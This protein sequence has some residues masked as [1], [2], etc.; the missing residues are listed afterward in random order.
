MRTTDHHEAL[1]RRGKTLHFARV[2]TKAP[3]TGEVEV[4]LSCVGVCGT[5]LQIL[6]GSRPDTA[7]ILGHEG[8]GIVVRAP[9]VDGVT[10]GDQVVF[11]PAAQLS[12]GRILGHNTSGLFQQYITLEPEAVRD[13]LIMS[14]SD[15]SATLCGILVEPLACVIYGYELLTRRVGCIRTA[16]V[17]GAGPVG[18]LAAIYL[19]DF[20]IKTFL[21]HT[22]PVRLQT[23]KR[24]EIASA[25]I[26][27][28]ATDDAVEQ[29][30]ARNGDYP[31][32]IAFICTTRIG[33]PVALWQAIRIVRHGGCVDLV[34]NYPEIGVGTLP[35]SASALRLV[36]SENVCGLPSEGKYLDTVMG[37]RRIAFTGHRG[38]SYAHLR[39]AINVLCRNVPAYS[40]MITHVLPLRESASAIQS[41]SE[42]RSH[43]VLGRD[44][45]KLAIDMSGSLSKDSSNIE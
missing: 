27:L 25:V 34:T 16:A 6:N 26:T 14:A 32:D 24:L 2:P 22:D 20:G 11:N 35:V 10:P 4:A 33:A 41:L 23:V 15:F 29:V 19:S 12:L 45:I 17:F 1:V 13:G 30:V 28:T 21:I 39:Q 44:C 36:R 31:I 37:G 38:T 18:I 42:S 9:G 43:T 40:R 3:K 7:E 5:D 8:I